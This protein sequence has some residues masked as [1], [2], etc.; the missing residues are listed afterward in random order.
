[1]YISS[2]SFQRI[3]GQFIPEAETRSTGRFPR[4]ITFHSLNE[5]M[6]I[7]ILSEPADTMLP[8]CKIFLEVNQVN[9]TIT[10]LDK[11]GGVP[12]IYRVLT[13]CLIF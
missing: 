4:S 9:L 10:A 2:L 8:Q 5:D 11:I 6:L 3:N 1:M 13:I 12:D 7:R